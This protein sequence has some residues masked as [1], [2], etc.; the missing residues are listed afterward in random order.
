[1]HAVRDCAFLPGPAGIWDG[2]WIA[3]VQHLSLLRMLGLGHT[4]PAA[5]ADLGVGGVSFGH[6]FDLCVLCLVLLAGSSLA[7]LV[8]TT[9][10][11]GRLGGEIVVK[12]SRLQGVCLGGFFE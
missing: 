9:A 7:M 3:L 8:L 1:M 2:E 4:L 11:S 5:G 10:G 12:V 6:F